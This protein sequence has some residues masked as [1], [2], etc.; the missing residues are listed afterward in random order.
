[1]RKLLIIKSYIVLLLFMMSFAAWSETR[2]VRAES[3]FQEGVTLYQQRYS[4]VAISP[5]E[6]AAKLGHA[7]A[8]YQVG[9][10]LRRRYTYITEEAEA[11]YL[12]AAEGGEIYAML[13]L[14]Q[15]GNFC[16]TLRNCD[17]DRELWV[18]RALDTVLPRAENGDTDS[19]MAVGAAYAVAGKPKKDFEW[20]KRAAESGDAFAQYWMAVMLDEMDRGFY[21]TEKGR[22][23]DMFKWLRASAEQGFPKAMF[24][25]AMEYRR[26]GRDEEFL[27]WVKRMGQ[28]DY[29]DA[30]YE[31]GLVLVGRSSDG[32][33]SRPP[34]EIVKGLA[35]LLAL[36]RQTGSS[37][38]K[39]SIDRRLP[40]LDPALVTKAQ[41]KSE[42]LLVDTP[43]L[44][45]L[46]K[47]G[48]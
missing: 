39:R 34:D 47:F 4:A 12:Q 25:L 13:R 43:I 21:W 27:V 19:M 28:T 8:A 6:E 3:L 10:I 44:H 9:E 36:H 1:M 22:R 7:G 42:T 17:Y 48:I 5:L 20:V 37:R 31:Y 11:Y 15:K 18:E 38:V 14:A 23:A 46:P 35:T 2:E 24:K 33:D 41:A 29:F 45:Y 40:D 32:K 16:G 30:L 26:D